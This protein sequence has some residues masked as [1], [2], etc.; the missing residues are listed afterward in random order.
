ML[1]R[2][3]PGPGCGFLAANVAEQRSR[4]HHVASSTGQ[5][6]VSADGGR[7]VYT[8]FDTWSLYSIMYILRRSEE[9][10]TGASH[11]VSG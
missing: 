5:V 6:Y 1:E 9:I 2:D 3:A 7:S 4:T 8:T 10:G 11:L